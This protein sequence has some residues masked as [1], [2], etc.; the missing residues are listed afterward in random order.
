MSEKQTTG[1][2]RIQAGNLGWF[3]QP[4]KLGGAPIL[5]SGKAL[6]SGPAGSYSLTLWAKPVDTEG[7][8][9]Y[10]PDGGKENEVF[11]ASNG[12]PY[13]FRVTKTRGVRIDV[14]EGGA[15]YRLYFGA[16]IGADGVAVRAL[17]GGGV[18]H[19]ENVVILCTL[20]R[21]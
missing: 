3:W 2:T 10:F 6:E 12:E 13:T 18:D 11:K 7:I 16:A 8:E 21:L 20:E 4:L 14:E 19:K 15:V 9:Q 5:L 17:A 1:S